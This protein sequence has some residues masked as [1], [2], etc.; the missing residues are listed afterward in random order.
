MNWLDQVNFDLMKKEIVFACVDVLICDEDGRVLLGRRTEPTVND[1]WLFGGRMSV[2]ETFQDTAKRV[3]K[4]ELDL[5]DYTWDVVL[6]H[7]LLDY[8]E[9]HQTHFLIAP[10][11]TVTVGTNSA[12]IDYHKARASHSEVRW[13]TSEEML[14]MEFHP[15][16]TRILDDAGVTRKRLEIKQVVGAVE[17]TCDF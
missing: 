15:Y 9:Y 11:V 3:L 5:D 8:P 7:Y 1:W 12:V 2:G 13:F 16:L 4:R 17:D 6:G 14:S 10:K